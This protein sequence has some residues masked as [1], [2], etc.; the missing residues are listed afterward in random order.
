MGI[1]QEAVTAQVD[2]IN[3]KLGEVYGALRHRYNKVIPSGWTDCPGN[4]GPE[5]LGGKDDRPRYGFSNEVISEVRTGEGDLVKKHY[6]VDVMLMGFLNP[7]ELDET[8]QVPKDH[9]RWDYLADIM[10]LAQAGVIDVENYSSSV[11]VPR[12]KG[13]PEFDA[14]LGMESAERVAMSDRLKKNIGNRNPETD[15]DLI[16]I[17]NYVT[18]FYV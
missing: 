6:P 18:Q 8:S 14:M 11:G 13:N 17:D 12:W 10:L 2:G 15:K 3:Q 1:E 4:F 5:V 16:A 9:W 7:S